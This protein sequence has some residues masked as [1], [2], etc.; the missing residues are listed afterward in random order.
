MKKSL[1]LL[2]LLTFGCSKKPV[3]MD[4]VLF[5]RADRWI[6][7]SNYSSFFFYNIKVYNGPAFT[8]HSNGEKKEKGEIKNGY[9]AGI[10]SGWD[11]DGNKRYSGS[12]RFGQ[13]H[14]S[15][16]GWHKNGKKKYEGE[17][18][19]GKQIDIW[20]Y[21]NKGGKKTTEEIYIVCDE[22]CEDEH[23]PIPCLREGKIK[24]SKEF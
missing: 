10:W 22:Q 16:I 7:N 11:K 15:W 5:D 8:K 24:T 6:T 12:Y 4:E 19:K 2:A 20:T 17:Y 23:Y 13:E 1:L 18:K 14:G 3:D 21:Y 9:K